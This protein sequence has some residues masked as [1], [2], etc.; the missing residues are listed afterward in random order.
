[1][2]FFFPLSLQ[3]ALLVAYRTE[4]SFLEP[5]K[6]MKHKFSQRAKFCLQL[7]LMKSINHYVFLTEPRM[8]Q[9]SEN[10]PCYESFF[11]L[12]THFS[13]LVLVVRQYYLHLN[14]SAR[15]GDV[16]L[17]ELPSSLLSWITNVC[18]HLKLSPLFLCF[19]SLN[20]F[21]SALR[22]PLCLFLDFLI[23]AFI[24]FWNYLLAWNIFR[25]FF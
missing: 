6:N 1:M 25:V 17:L 13:E 24:I 5:A 11:F 14:V 21:L 7:I 20:S 10:L 15:R 19:C 18:W 12:W 3:G 23:I 8:W 2:L 22:L 4:N 16:E 9:F